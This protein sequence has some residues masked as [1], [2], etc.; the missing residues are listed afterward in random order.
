MMTEIR[1]HMTL[2]KTW[3]IA[4][5]YNRGVFIMYIGNANEWKEPETVPSEKELKQYIPDLINPYWYVDGYVYY[6]A[7]HTIM[8]TRCDGK[9]SIMLYRSRPGEFTGYS[10]TDVKD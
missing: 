10:I 6:K 1:A 2:R 4:R 8:R 3:K 5:K 9:D 7:G